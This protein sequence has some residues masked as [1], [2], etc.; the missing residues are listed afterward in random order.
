MSASVPGEAPAAQG[1]SGDTPGPP[2][3]VD[4]EYWLNQ[5][6]D[7]PIAV[8]R[9]NAADGY[10]RPLT[11]LS[12]DLVLTYEEAGVRKFYF[13]MLGVLTPADAPDPYM[14]A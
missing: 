13:E 6:P 2:G 11:P 14:Q 8:T 12:Q 10:P 1:E 5:W 4:W 9:A 3:L 7:H